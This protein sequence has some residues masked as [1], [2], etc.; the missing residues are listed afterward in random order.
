MQGQG[1]LY[2]ARELEVDRLVKDV[3]ERRQDLRAAHV[4]RHGIDVVRGE[5]QAIIIE[6]VFGEEM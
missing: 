1:K 5:L 4:G 2:L 6:S 3:L